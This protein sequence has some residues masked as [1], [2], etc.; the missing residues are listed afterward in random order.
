M[1]ER[2]FEYLVKGFLK[3]VKEKLPGWIKENKQERKNVLGELEEHVWD[4]AGELSDTG[5]PTEQSVRLAISHMGNPSTIAREYKK[6]GT[7][8]FYISEELWPLY[9]KVLTIVCSII[10]VVSVVFLAL[11]LITGG[12][13]DI[14]IS[15]SGIFVAFSI[16]TIIFV[17]LSMEGYFPED[18][19]SPTD[20]KRKEKVLAKSK[21]LGLPV[22]Q[23]T[24]KQLKPFVKSGGKIAEGI[25]GIVG[26]IIFF[27]LPTILSNMIVA[28]TSTP[29]IT[30]SINTG[31][32]FFISIG[33][34]ISIVEGGMNLIRGIIGNQEP[35]IHQGILGVS[36]GLKIVNAIVFGWIALTPEIIPWPYWNGVTEVLTIAT[37]APDFYV[38]A[39]GLVLLIAVIILLTMIEDIYWIAK[40]ENYKL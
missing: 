20:V 29:W 12:L 7:P 15:F 38:L 39:S 3:E 11:N 34:I 25:V 8:K 6:R 26:G 5:K 21:A 19:V 35:A 37:I 10:I 1:S 9:K 27:I 36:I 22:S 33:G 28:S 14:S 13:I 2:N 17:A 18:F 16:I 31:I 24:G 23:K 30:I 40:L 4:K 32:F